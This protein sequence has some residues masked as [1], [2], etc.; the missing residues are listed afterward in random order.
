MQNKNNTVAAFIDKKDS[1][2]RAFFWI[3]NTA[4]TS[5]GVFRNQPNVCDRSFL[6][7]I[8]VRLCYKYAS[9]LF[10]QFLFSISCNHS[11]RQIHI[12]YS[13]LYIYQFHI[14]FS[15][16]NAINVHMY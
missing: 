7:H 1:F 10:F 16:S 8:D 13:I 6:L 3:K 2:Q 11:F 9:T 15:V 4:G 5:R 12:T 14:Y